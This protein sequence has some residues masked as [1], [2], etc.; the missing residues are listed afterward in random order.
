MG[1]PSPGVPMRRS[2]RARL[3]MG[4][5]IAVLA[6]LL[7]PYVKWRRDMT[8][9]T[10]IYSDMYA[11]QWALDAYGTEH[12]RF[13]G[14][15]GPLGA[16]RPLLGSRL[17]A[18]VPSSD[19]W[20]RPLLYRGPIDGD[21]GYVIVSHGAD[22]RA[23]PWSGATAWYFDCDIS[24][25]PDEY[26]RIPGLG[27]SGIPPRIWELWWDPGLVHSRTFAHEK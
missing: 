18:S 12:G 10:R 21:E 15:S 11:I 3:G 25:S 20:G 9:L 24:M 2:R 23:T 8:R 4:L 27:S 17:P 13:P 14:G 16:I 22:G 26:P 6:T 5:G 1:V 19:A 7:A